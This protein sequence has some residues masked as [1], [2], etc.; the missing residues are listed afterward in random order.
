MSGGR[1]SERRWRKMCS[2]ELIGWMR[3]KRWAFGSIAR[4]LESWSRVRDFLGESPRWKAGWPP[5]GRLLGRSRP[6][7]SSRGP[8]ALQPR[9]GRPCIWTTLFCGGSG[10]SLMLPAGKY[11]LSLL[12][13]SGGCAPQS[14]AKFNSSWSAT[15]EPSSAAGFGVLAWCVFPCLCLQVRIPRK[16]MTAFRSLQQPWFKVFN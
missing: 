16:E 10:F 15:K 1:A 14:G 8:A 9:R 2:A 6:S 12:L 4:V 7:Q 5:W 3:N 11:V 13:P